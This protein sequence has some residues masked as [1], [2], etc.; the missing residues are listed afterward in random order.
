[1]RSFLAPLGLLLAIAA[2][3]QAADEVKIDVI[4][5]VECE[6]HTKKGDSISVHYR[7]SLEANGEELFKGKFMIVL[8]KRR[9]EARRSTML[10]VVYSWEQGL[11]DMCVGEKRKLT[12]PPSLGYG[13]RGMGPIPAKSVLIFET[14]LMEINN[15]KDE[16]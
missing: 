14:E 16:L 12:I 7:G 9:G 4:N 10:I 2:M 3:A 1:M 11:L 6:R 5:K 8:A 15:A 13:D